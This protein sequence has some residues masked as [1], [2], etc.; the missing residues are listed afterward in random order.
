MLPENASTMQS[1]SDTEKHQ[2]KCGGVGSG[3]EPVI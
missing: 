3:Q 1:L 2:I